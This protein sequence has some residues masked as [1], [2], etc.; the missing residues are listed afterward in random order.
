MAQLQD[1]KCPNCGGAMQFDIARQKLMCTFC[2]T[3]IDIPTLS[4]NVGQQGGIDNNNPVWQRNENNVWNQEDNV[5]SFICNSCGGEIIGDQNLASS[6]CPFC[7][8]QVV[9]SGRLSGQLRP[10]F[11]IPFK[12][13][14]NA[15]KKRYYEHI[16]G[17]KLLPKVFRKENHID[18]IKGIY[19]PFWLFNCD[20]SADIALRAMKTK[21]W[22]DSQFEYCEKSYYRLIRSG[23]ISFDRVPVDGSSKIANDLIESIEPFDWNGAVIFNSAYLAGYMADKYDVPSHICNTRANQ[24]IAQTAIN[25]FMQNPK[26]FENIQVEKS[27]VILQNGRVYYAMYPVWLLN[28]TWQGKKFVFAMNGQTGKFVGDLPIS[29]K[30]SFKWFL[31]SALITSVGV[32]A[33][34][35]ILQLL[36]MM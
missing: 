6:T 2:D 1:Y 17:K 25:A 35:L 29:K 18:D 5:T 26:E 9:M 24:R 34:I 23:N 12:L 14:K 7:G 10:D 4:N 28:T 30:E 22:S 31:I 33:A 15:A 8:N 3:L 36:Q 20:A 32:Y 19:V 21:R 13:D 11:I 16:K 27:N